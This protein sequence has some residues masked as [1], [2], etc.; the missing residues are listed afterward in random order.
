MLGNH[1]IDQSGA[2]RRHPEALLQTR[3][4][5]GLAVLGLLQEGEHKLK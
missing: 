1:G 5:Q 4:G 2:A 3:Q